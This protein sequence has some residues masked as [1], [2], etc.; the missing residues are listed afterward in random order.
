[1]TLNPMMP[2][3]ETLCSANYYAPRGRKRLYMLGSELSQRY[4]YPTDLLIGIIGNEGSGK[5]TVIKGLFPGLELTNDDE[6]VNVSPAPLF[7]FSEDDFFSGHTFHIDVRFEGA[8]HQMYEIVDAVNT[9]VS[10]G[11][12][13]IIEHFDLLYPH[14]GYN[15][16]FIVSIGEEVSVYRP[17][18]FGPSP[19]EIKKKIDGTHMFRLMAHSAEDIVTM[20]LQ[21]E[22]GYDSSKLHS[23]VKHG[24]IIGFEEEP[25]FDIAELESKVLEVI[26]KDVK[27]T[28]SDEK[29]ICVGDRC[30]Y[31]TGPR[32]HVSS[33]GK[34]E[35]FR[36]F[37]EFRFDPVSGEYLLVGI[38]GQEDVV[39]LDTFPPISNV[40]HRKHL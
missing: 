36:L 39:G 21:D 29:H 15:A 11:R 14:L 26:A 6:G 12:R 37:K 19:L 22:Y 8:F 25:S 31:C 20:I 35:Y 17:S 9:A 16:Q 1:M 7:S 34:I 30:M 2:I 24:F 18:V 33:S 28:P 32:I 27:I 5:S 40:I 38:V 4:L 13:V 10:H 23:D 3:A